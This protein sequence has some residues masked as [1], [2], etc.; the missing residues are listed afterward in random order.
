[1]SVYES[2]EK[3]RCKR[4]CLLFVILILAVVLVFTLNIA[5]GSVEI[6]FQEVWNILLGK[7][8]CDK[9]QTSIV[10]KI[11]LPRTL[12]T[13]A[14]GVCLAVSGLL[15]Q[16][17]FSNPIVEPY[18]L[19]ISSGAMM[20]VG[21]VLLGGY[22]LGIS[23]TSPMVMFWGALLGAFLVMLIV[24]L[25]ARKVK[26]I[27]TLLV[28]GMM[29]GYVCSAVT[30]LLTAFADKEAIANY[31]LW[32]MGS[33]SGFTWQQVKILWVVTVVFTLAAM[34][35]SKPLN[36][37]LLGERYAQSMGVGIKAFR[38]MIVVIASVLT[39]VLTA[40]AGPISFVGLA[41]PHITRILFGTSDNR[42]LLP[43][44]ALTGALMTGLCDLVARML[45][46]PHEIP[47]GAIT[48]IIGAP[49][50]VYLLMRRN[51]GL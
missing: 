13:V 20:F 18:V 17:F 21:I 16:I 37:L 33:F 34:M 40:F 7:E 4:R 32:T 2:I 27:V 6:P 44:A 36:A 42:I 41:V 30:S 48:S 8:G 9:V 19:G 10:M 26:S 50:V 38:M 22:A 15:L 1:M 45:F 35:M 46:A 14:G 25:A 23:V 49:L 39:A 28:I 29:A 12:A 5:L 11:R 51:N 31:T 24:V 3:A 43:A 47:L